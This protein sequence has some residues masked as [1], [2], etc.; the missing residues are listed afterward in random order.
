M[1]VADSYQAMVEDR[2]YRA[3][4]PKQF[5]FEQLIAGAGTQF[6]PAVVAAFLRAQGVTVPESIEEPLNLTQEPIP[7][8]HTS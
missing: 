3:A 4:L 1:T 5:A 8:T 6:D 7:I 2:P